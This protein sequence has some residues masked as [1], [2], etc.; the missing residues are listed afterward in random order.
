MANKTIP[1]LPEQTGK[2]DN[3]LLAIVDSGETTTSKIKVS[4]LLAGV[5]GAS[6]FSASTE[7]T[8]NIL[9]IDKGHS[10]LYGDVSNETTINDN[11]F[12]GG[13]GNT[14][15]TRTYTNLPLNRNV[16]IGGYLN[17]FWAAQN[18]IGS[19]NSAMIGGT[20][21]RLGR[22]SDNSAMIG[23]D[24]N[25]IG[26]GY[27]NFY[28]GGQN[29][30]N[31][32]SNIAILGGNSNAITKSDSVIAGGFSNN[33]R[34]GYGFISGNDNYINS[35]NQVGNSIVGGTTNYIANAN[36]AFIGGGINNDILNSSVVN[37]S[38][39]IGGDTNI[40]NTHARS[41]ILGGSG[42]TTSYDDEV[43]CE[44]LTTSGQSRGNFYNNLSGDT[45][46]IDWNEGN[47]QKIYMTG[48]TTLDFSNVK[49]GATYKL[50]VENGG[51]HSITGVTSSGFT[52]LCEGGS[53]PNITNNGVDLCVLEVMDTD[54]LVR[55]FANF[56][57]P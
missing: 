55:H 3:D 2:T 46:T 44:H 14:I 13:S 32:Q 40:I 39:I 47:L 27:R 5:G 1:Q 29:N 23:G 43:V 45:F 19:N 33:L 11:F 53:I 20:S 35:Y 50:Q 16:F 12:A 57:T 49:N 31:E 9:Q 34:S 21:N 52:I 22:Q 10:I 38:A 48:D 8:S 36:N 15:N 18:N 42:L 4:T 37:N 54:I 56:A 24:N 6:F 30:Q 25:S 7:N 28:G 26:Y 41:V 17:E 51:T